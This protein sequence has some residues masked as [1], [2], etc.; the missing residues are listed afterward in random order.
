MQL[1]LDITAKGLIL[2]SIPIISELLLVFVLVV[3]VNRADAIALAEHRKKAFVME[4][5]E[6]G[7][8]VYEELNVLIAYYTSRQPKLL[9]RFSEIDQSILARLQNIET[10]LS[11]ASDQKSLALRKSFRV[12]A[13]NLIKE[14]RECR[15]NLLVSTDNPAGA[16]WLGLADDTRASAAKFLKAS[17]ALMLLQTRS[18]GASKE[19]QV[20]NARD[21]VRYALMVSVCVNI[22]MALYLTLFFSRNISLRVNWI[23]ENIKCIPAGA[24]MKHQLDGFDE[25]AV[26]D[27]FVHTVDQ[28]L[29]EKDDQRNAIL[30]MVGHDLRSPLSAA[31][32]TLQVMENGG[33]GE[34]SDTAQKRLRSTVAVLDT[35]TRMIRDLLDTETLRAGKFDLHLAKV[36][37]KE[38]CEQA[39][40]ALLPLAE[41]RRLTIETKCESVEGNFDGDRILQ[42]LNNLIGNAVKFSPPQ[43]VITISLVKEGNNALLKIADQGPGISPEEINK[44]FERY[45][46]TGT[47]KRIVGSM[48]LGLHICKEIVTKHGGEIGVESEQDKGTCFWIKLPL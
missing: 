12:S 45:Y 9:E 26:I 39:R 7:L 15:N 37:L 28:Q 18:D 43:S 14:I 17:D 24:E 1:K 2:I 4:M 11:L 3:L 32:M 22:V 42:V 47:G 5:H 25:L 16:N 36:D 27:Q 38:V 41:S 10:N 30:S 34:V 6:V 19:D 35:L 8:Q 20:Q 13:E 23:C 48:G 21:L 40:V 29:K 31:Q 44:V 46:Q 33:Y